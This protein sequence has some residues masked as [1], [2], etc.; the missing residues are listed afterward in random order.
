MFSIKV[1]AP[2]SAA[3]WPTLATG[4]LRDQVACIL[5]LRHTL[6]NEPCGWHRL[7]TATSFCLN[8]ELNI[9]PSRCTTSMIMFLQ[10]LRLEFGMTC[11]LMSP[12]CHRRAS[13]SGGWRR[14]SISCYPGQLS[15]LPSV[16]REISSGKSTVMRR[17][18]RVKAGWLIPYV[19]KHVGGR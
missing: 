13:L 9:P 4:A 7:S 19:D 10:S 12:R 5:W 17:G 1:R 18:W 2:D 6:H 15:F 14:H 8:V 11:H 3:P 16:G